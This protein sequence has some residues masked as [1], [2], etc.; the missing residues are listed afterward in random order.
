MNPSSEKV[1]AR[2]GPGVGMVVSACQACGVLLY[3]FADLPETICLSSE[4]R[5]KKERIQRERRDSDLN[6]E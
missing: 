6:G 1:G 3:C 5:K 2:E 4:E